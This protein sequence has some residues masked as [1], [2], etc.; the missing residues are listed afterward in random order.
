MYPRKYK[1]S[2]SYHSIQYFGKQVLHGSKYSISMPQTLMSDNPD[3][4]ILHV[5]VSG[6]EVASENHNSHMVER[7]QRNGES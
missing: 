3:T 2:T 4:A 5:T 6:L 1:T 7:G